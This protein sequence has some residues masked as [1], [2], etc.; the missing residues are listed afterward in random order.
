[1]FVESIPLCRGGCIYADLV[2][3]RQFE[4]YFTLLHISDYATQIAIAASRIPP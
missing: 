1:M 2:P 3:S 4:Y